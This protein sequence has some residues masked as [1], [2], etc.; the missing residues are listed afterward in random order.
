MIDIS[1]I[2]VF[3]IPFGDGFCMKSALLFKPSK[4]NDSGKDQKIIQYVNMNRANH[5]FQLESLKRN[6]EKSQRRNRKK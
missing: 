2:I 5:Y 4:D 6:S 3:E 1:Q